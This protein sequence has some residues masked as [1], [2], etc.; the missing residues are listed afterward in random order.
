M[1]QVLKKSIASLLVMALVL[2]LSPVDAG[3]AKKAK[4]SKSKANVTVGKTVK[5]TVKNGVKKAKV[6]WATSKKSVAKIT[7][8]S[9]K[10][11]SAYATIKGVKK[12]TATITASYKLGKKTTKLK[13]KVT[14]KNNDI[15]TPAPTATSSV[16][17][18]VTPTATPTKKPSTPTPTPT[19]T[20]LP[21]VK[22]AALTAYKLNLDP[23]VKAKVVLDGAMTGDDAWVDSYPTNLLA[24]SLSV[25][26]TTTITAA[27][28]NLM[29][30][31]T[32]LYVLI[33]VTKPNAGANDSV[34][35]YFD[36]DAAATGKYTENTN[37]TAYK[38]PVSENPTA[39]QNG[40]A[41][42]FEAKTSS[43]AK[44][45]TVEAKISFKAI[46]PAVASNCAIE[47][48]LNDG[49]KATINYFDSVAD[50]VYD[51]DKDSWSMKDNGLKVTSDTAAFGI[52]NMDNVVLQPQEAIKNK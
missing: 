22:N 24:N 37:A 15:I 28:A 10:G 32:A 16:T 44:G 1:K 3:A 18:T 12:G 51:K 33:N 13:C 30:D 20:P 29:W 19:A 21:V 31:E 8:K 35:I 39:I 49:T 38:V 17:P 40:S 25:R 7:K 23:K 46:Q 27:T 14:V 36:E 48:Q 45:Y 42:T 52:V 41:Y 4:L 34:N 43:D 9:T 11:K 50:Q 47:I 6:T 2:S 5:I 26:G